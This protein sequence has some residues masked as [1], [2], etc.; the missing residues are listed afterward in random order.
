MSSVR[1]RL[2]T[3]SK[4]TITLIHTIFS[5]INLRRAAAAS[6]R[7]LETYMEPT[8]P[9]PLRGAVHFLPLPLR[10]PNNV[11]NRPQEEKITAVPV[12]ALG[13]SGWFSGSTTFQTTSTGISFVDHSQA[14]ALAPPL[15]TPLSEIRLTDQREFVHVRKNGMWETFNASVSGSD[16]GSLGVRSDSGTGSFAL[17]FDTTS[18]FT[19]TAGARSGTSSSTGTAYRSED[20]GQVLLAPPVDSS[21]RWHWSPVCHHYFVPRLVILSY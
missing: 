3:F 2:P 19:G 18:S 10:R 21:R 14:L 16:M 15:P 17:S 6:T 7:T 8:Y 1:H 4:L 9:V 5:I 11:G 13:A 12:S 20:G